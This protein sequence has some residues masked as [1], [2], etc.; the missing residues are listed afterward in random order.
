MAA[1]YPNLLASGVNDLGRFDQFDLFAGESKIVTSQGQAANGQA[2]AQFQV[3]ALDANGR[4]VPYVSTGDYATGTVTFTANP[5]AADTITIN[6]QAIT[7]VAGTPAANQVEIEATLAETLTS[8]VALINAHPATFNVTASASATV[9]TLTAI[10]EGTAGNTIALADS[11]TNTAVSGATLTDVG[12][13]EV[14]PSGDAVAIAAQAVDAATPGNWL[15]VFIGGVFN[16]EALLWPAGFITLA[17]RKAAFAG[18]P[19]SVTQLL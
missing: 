13:S 2:I 8:T 18:T 12:A 19:I 15:P 14:V 9:L 4:Y 17:D 16:H 6:G 3:L 10:P 5:T 7:F 11:S 1:T